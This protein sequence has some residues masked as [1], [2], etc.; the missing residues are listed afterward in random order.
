MRR[1]II[2]VGSGSLYSLQLCWGGSALLPAAEACKPRRKVSETGPGP[3]GDS[4][5]EE[6]PHRFRVIRDELTG[7]PLIRPAETVFPGQLHKEGAER[8]V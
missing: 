1:L 6:W 2:F 5:A 8:L 3:G 4:W 7:H